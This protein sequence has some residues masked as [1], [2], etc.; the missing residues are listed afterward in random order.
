MKKHTDRPKTVLIAASAASMIDQFNLPNIRLLKSLGYD[1][2]V[3][4]N[5]MDGNTCTDEKIKELTELLERMSVDCYQIDFDRKVTDVKAHIKAFRQLDAVATGRAVPLNVIRHHKI[6]PVDGCR[7][8]FMH[9][10]SPIG[11]AVGRIIAKKHHI[12]TIY[13]AH[14]FHFYDGA[15]LKNWLIFYPVE[16]ELSRITDVLITI[17][18]EDYRRA[19]KKFHAGK[20]VYIPGVGIDIEKFSSGLADP[21]K[22]RRELGI[23]SATILLLSVG[24]L[25]PRKDHETVI[26]ALA[27][28]SRPKIQYLI[29]GKGEMEHRLKALAGRLG[30][31][32]KVHFLGF[33]TDISE[34]CQ[35]ADIFV[36]PSLQEGLPLALMEAAACGT[37]VVCSDIRGNKDL[38]HDERFLF[39]GGSTDDAVRCLKG[40]L[41]SRKNIKIFA[42]KTVEANKKALRRCD[43]S[44]VEKLMKAVYEDVG[45]ML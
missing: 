4:A 21:E 10:H 7:Y 28:I 5:F 38:V 31:N 11:G 3:A 15:P 41:T 9:V 30:L 43:L 35:A 12:R 23:D 45:N 37:P 27:E 17:N 2:D 26:R 18:K 33:R 32:G 39:K 44:S 29:A 24:E 14:G 34:L 6:C 20:V 1:V 40:L 8:S 19:K 36:F 42:K 22:K 16:K 13:T 25:I